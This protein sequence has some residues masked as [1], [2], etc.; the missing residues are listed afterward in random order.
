MEAQPDEQSR[1]IISIYK[2]HIDYT[3]SRS[4]IASPIFLNEI[5]GFETNA[6]PQR[7]KFGAPCHPDVIVRSSFNFENKKIHGGTSFLASLLVSSSH[8]TIV[9]PFTTGSPFGGQNY[10]DLV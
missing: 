10:S 5:A 2:K 4:T 8:E 9:N 3:K 1:V 7:L 6:R